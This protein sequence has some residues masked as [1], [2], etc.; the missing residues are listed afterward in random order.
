M[1]ITK[2]DF[3][4][5]TKLDEDTLEVWLAEKWIIPQ[6]APA[7]NAFSEAD[8]ARAN[9]I[10]ELMND[11]GVN[12]EGIGIVLDLLDQMHSLRRAMSEKMLAGRT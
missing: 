3:L 4:Y 1:I 2:V 12:R 10:R 5:R 7:G 8:V 9:L 11:M 6:D